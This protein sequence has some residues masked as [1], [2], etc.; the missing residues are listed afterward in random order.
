MIPTKHV[1]VIIQVSITADVPADDRKLPGVAKFD[2]D[3]PGESLARN[4]FPGEL[5]QVSELIKSG[6]QMVR[7]IEGRE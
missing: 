2:S 3:L 5:S 1:R 7:K 6:M 4:L